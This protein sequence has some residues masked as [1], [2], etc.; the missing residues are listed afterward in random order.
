MGCY[1]KTLFFS[2]GDCASKSKSVSNLSFSSL[3]ESIK[4]TQMSVNQSAQTSTVT[5]QNQRIVLNK[6][7]AGTANIKI[8][9]GMKLKIA[10][11]TQM[12]STIKKA[13]MDELAANIQSQLDNTLDVKSDIGVDQSIQEKITN[14]KK[15]I[16]SVVKKNTTITSSNKAAAEAVAVNNQEIVIDFAEFNS[17]MLEAIV[18]RFKVP[19]STG[20]IPEI[21]INQD[22]IADI[23]MESALS[24]VAEA[25]SQDKQVN[26]A[27]TALKEALVAKGMGIGE[28]T[29]G[30]VKELGTAVGKVVDTTG[31]LGGKAIETGGSVL[32]T[33][34]III[35]LVIVA[36]IIGFVVFGKSL[37]SNPDAI[38]AIGSTASSM[39]SAGRMTGA[40]S[41]IPSVPGLPKASFGFGS[42]GYRF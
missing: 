24:A 15:S 13:D 38:K 36:A 8:S 39:S 17:D 16:I 2:L 30:A 26:K 11:K 1:G 34:V 20:A 33:Y 7:P 6:F 23:Q 5:V 12:S 31:E 42:C 27:E 19:G 22:L 9:Q 40:A 10:S 35:G 4:D 37:V 25:I 18:A 41:A 32:K 14:V 28:L 21:I 29:A 3:S